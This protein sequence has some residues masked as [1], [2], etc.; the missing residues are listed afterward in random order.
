MGPSFL[1]EMGHKNWKHSG[2]REGGNTARFFWGTFDVFNFAFR[3]ILKIWQ[4][5]MDPSF[6]N[7]KHWM[8][9]I[10][11][12]Q[13]LGLLSSLDFVG[14]T[15]RGKCGTFEFFGVGSMFS[16]L[17]LENILDKQL[18]TPKGPKFLDEKMG[19]DDCK[20]RMDPIFLPPKL[21]LLGAL[22]FA[23]WWN[24]WTRN[25]KHRMDTKSK[26]SNGPKCSAPKVGPTMFSILPFHTK[27]KLGHNIENIDFVSLS[28]V[29]VDA[30]ITTSNAPKIRTQKL[31]A[32]NGP[33]VSAQTWFH[34]MF[35]ILPV[36]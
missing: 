1:T 9:P 26:T 11:P 25:R 32:S 10:C 29:N 5:R 24:F 15:K 14:Y 19:H 12:P 28:E 7:W 33:N 3:N 16:I 30:E 2:I 17:P 34:L 8:D 35:S 27:C 18:T 22:H 6:S 36:D 23:L 31:R 21:D 4:H 13:R 20:H